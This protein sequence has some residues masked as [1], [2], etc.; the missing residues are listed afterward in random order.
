MIT[1]NIGATK[2]RVACNVAVRH[3]SRAEAGNMALISH[4]GKLFQMK[5]KRRRSLF[6]FAKEML[7][8]FIFKIKCRRS[9][10]SFENER[11]QTGRPFSL[12]L[13]R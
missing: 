11:G 2:V 7:T 9:L 6:F 3:A 10:T 13:F 8:L 4:A 5:T 12:L 1:K